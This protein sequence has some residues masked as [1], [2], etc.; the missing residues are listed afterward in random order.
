MTS[1]GSERFGAAGIVVAAALLLLPGLGELDLWA[2]DEPRYAEIA[3]EIARGDGA[4]RWFLLELNGE[5]YT[6]KPPLY[7]WLAA[8]PGLGDGR[9]S[10]G[11]ARLPSA[12]AGI[13]VVTMTY[14]LGLRLF[15][16]PAAAVYAAGI[17]LTS[18]RFA[19]LARRAQLDVLLAAF[20]ALALLAFARGDRG[21]GSRT[22][23][24]AL[25]HTA[26]GA[27]VLTKGP[28]GLLP[29]GIVVA[30]L[31]VE[32]RFGECRG[33]FP[34][35]GLAL[36]LGP[37]LL[38]LAAAAALAPAGFLETA[39]VENVFGRFVAGASHPR[40]FYYYLVQFPA[41][42][43]PWTLL[44]PLAGVALARCWKQNPA[45]GRNGW[46]L[47]AI[48]LGIFFVVF[49]LSTEKRGLYLL[50]A[51]PAAALLCGAALERALAGRR[52]LPLGLQA[53]LGI[54]LAALAIGGVA[55][56][57]GPAIEIV[58]GFEIPAALGV[59]VAAISLGALLLG[60]AW[61]RRQD[62]ARLQVGLALVWVFA[63]ELSLLRVGYPAFD[64]AK[65]P[66][67]IAQAANRLAGPNGTIGL[68]REAA[69]LGG[70]LYYGRLYGDRPIVLLERTEDV[71][72]FIER[73]ENIVVAGRINLAEL[74]NLEERESLRQ[75]SRAIA[76]AVPAHGESP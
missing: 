60:A 4:S 5:A 18:F 50:P 58:A 7:Y 9:V 61:A 36:S 70:L 42:F 49:S 25:F 59:P 8:L 23:N 46:R 1:T 16:S 53:A 45:P 30:F 40:P 33:W 28:V 19:H 31:A 26:I 34:A 12:L 2:P 65:S 24:V 72:V 64:V 73:G 17:L 76:L 3:D 51:F 13:A 47:A 38:W 29:L 20:E 10:A 48:W 39:V 56:A 41:D 6:Q 63:I 55:L 32:R 52:S 35:W 14:F 66:R 21:I 11:E 44:W 54:G 27:A 62:G 15:A 43:M 71:E 69:L 37:A 68:Y 74:P 67:A 57:A 75:G 22:R